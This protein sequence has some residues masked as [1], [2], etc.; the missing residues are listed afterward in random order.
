MPGAERRARPA[1]R[2]GV[3]AP[4]PHLCLP[5]SCRGRDQLH[6]ERVGRGVAVDHGRDDAGRDRTAQRHRG[7]LR[8]RAVRGREPLVADAQLR[9]RLLDD[10]RLSRRGHV[11]RDDR[12]GHPARELD[13]IDRRAP[14]DD[15]SLDEIGGRRSPA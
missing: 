15:A 9:E 13:D 14:C 10:E 1:S 5:V 11:R 6:H 2:G 8:F 4:L 7:D 12:G 3:D